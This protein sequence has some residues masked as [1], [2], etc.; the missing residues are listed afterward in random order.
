MEVR[1]APRVA[2]LSMHDY[3]LQLAA[4]VVVVIV[5]NLLALGMSQC[6]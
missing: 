2:T 4:A 5:V 6:S 1:N 3:W